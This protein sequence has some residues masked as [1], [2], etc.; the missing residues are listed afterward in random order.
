MLT[1]ADTK[2]SIN[3]GE[4]MKKTSYKSIKTERG[5]ENFNYNQ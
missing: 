5:T 4:M 2:D 3:E 1:I